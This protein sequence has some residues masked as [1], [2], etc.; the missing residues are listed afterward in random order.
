MDRIIADA[1]NGIFILAYYQGLMRLAMNQPEADHM[2]SRTQGEN[3]GGTALGG[4]LTC[5]RSRLAKPQPL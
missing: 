3:V 2:A 4:G 5:V 1:D